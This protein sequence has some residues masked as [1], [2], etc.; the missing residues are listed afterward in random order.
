MTPPA[1]ITSC[2]T[3]TKTP[4]TAHTHV[5]SLNKHT[6]YHIPIDS[7]AHKTKEE[8][9]DGRRRQEKKKHICKEKEK[10]DIPAQRTEKKTQ[11]IEH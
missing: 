11:Y 6:F 7:P 8:K 4:T 9:K 5:F 10:R 3:H 2:A 1:Q